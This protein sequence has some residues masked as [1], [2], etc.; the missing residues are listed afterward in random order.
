MRIVV[1]SKELRAGWTERVRSREV[2]DIAADTGFDGTV[3]DVFL[4]TEAAEAVTPAGTT[5][6][7]RLERAG[8]GLV[9]LVARP[10]QFVPPVRVRHR[11]QVAEALEGIVNHGWDGATAVRFVIIGVDEDEGYLRQTEFALDPAG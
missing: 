4:G 9:W 3:I 6:V 5:S 1:D 2:L 11:L 7:A 8:G 10:A